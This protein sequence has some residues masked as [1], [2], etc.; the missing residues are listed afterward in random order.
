MPVC[1]CGRRLFS[2]KRYRCAI[3]RAAARSA[4]GA[5]RAMEA[6]IEAQY[7]RA[8]QMYRRSA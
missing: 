2:R 1:R 4:A 7:Q 5:A 8:R 3:C 6:R